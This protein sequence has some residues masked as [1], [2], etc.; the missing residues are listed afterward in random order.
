MEVTYARTN[1]RNGVREKIGMR[2]I[3]TPSADM[4]KMLHLAKKKTHTLHILVIIELR[5]LFVFGSYCYHATYVP[6][7]KCLELHLAF[8]FL[9]ELYQ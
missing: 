4:K 5:C 1:H 7:Y 6:S 9:L 2:L 8:F 3:A